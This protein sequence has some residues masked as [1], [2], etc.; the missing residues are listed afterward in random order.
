MADK[1][2]IQAL[3]EAWG[4]PGHEYM[5]RA[6]IEQHV[7][8]LADELRVDNGGNLICRMGSGGKKIMIAAHMDEIGLV[9]SALDKPGFARFTM[10]GG[11]ILLLLIGNR[12]RF[13]DGTIGTIGMEGSALLPT[14][15]PTIKQLFIDFSTG[16]ENGGSV[17][18]GDPAA[19]TREFAVRGDRLIAK[20]MDDRIGCAVA[21]EAMRA[22]KGKNLPNELY[23]VF[24]TQ[25]EVGIRGA[26]VAANSIA[27]DYGI[28]LDV[29]ATGDTPKNNS[30]AVRLG[31][32]TAIKVVDSGHI[33]PP[34]IKE[35]MVR[36]AEA[37]GIR[38]QLEVLSGGTTDA[39][40]IQTALSGI[41]S[42]T[43]SIPCRYVHT[44]SETVDINDVQASIDL[45]VALLEQPFDV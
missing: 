41:P 45:L 21:I 30:M 6:L 16:S 25:E 43:I 29:T 31:A 32:G 3:V 9:V 42:G 33:V 17:R 23:F 13:A 28:A 26:R 37:A 22:L 19:L 10:T 11:L 27:P 20:S 39:A 38:Y 35:L 2:L 12:V 5:V 24:T 14:E 44:T 18:V 4:P 15:M 34:A 36:R 40:A 8:D 7:R 1:A